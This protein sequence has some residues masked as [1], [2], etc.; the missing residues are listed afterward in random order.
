M[1]LKA[2]LYVLVTIITLWSLT[3][4]DYEKFLKKN[5]LLEFKILF[6]LICMSI[7]YLVVNFLYD[8]FVNSK[9]L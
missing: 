8:F 3:S 2:L 7:S 1:V 6:L 5:K 9:W 4:I